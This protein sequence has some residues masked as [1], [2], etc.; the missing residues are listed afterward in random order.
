MRRVERFLAYGN[1]SFTDAQGTNS[2][3]NSSRGIVG[4]PLEA[5]RIFQPQYINPLEYNNAIRGNLNLDYRFGK[6][7]G[8][9]VFQ[10]LGLSL[11]GIFTS[12]HPYTRGEGAGD[13]TRTR[14]RQPTEALGAST[15]PATFQLDLRL[16]KTFNIADVLDLNIYIFVINVT[17][18]RN[19]SNVHVRSGSAEDDGFLGGPG[20][21]TAA[22]LGPDFVATYNA[23][24]N[25]Y[26]EEWRVGN[27]GASVTTN[28]FMWGPPRQVR[29][30]IRLEY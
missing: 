10:E 2:F 19:V 28:P 25:L 27:S 21:V 5:D 13:L 8:G 1:I 4:A 17:D 29:L 20:E 3:P 11:L 7:D 12:G 16:D 22:S 15:T 9:P 26:S 23:I 6:D 30:G 24:N 14:F 18:A